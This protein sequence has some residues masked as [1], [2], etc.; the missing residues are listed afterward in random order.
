MTESNMLSAKNSAFAR[1]SLDVW[2]LLIDGKMYWHP[3]L[4]KDTMQS[5]SH[6]YKFTGIQSPCTP[7]PIKLILINATSQ[8]KLKCLHRIGLHN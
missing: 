6:Q 3:W 7:W 2:V 8:N 5:I 4:I 1:C